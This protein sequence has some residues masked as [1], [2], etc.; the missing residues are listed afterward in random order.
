MTVKAQY[1]ILLQVGFKKP[2]RAIP[3]YAIISLK[4][5]TKGA[6]GALK[7]KNAHRF[8]PGTVALREIRRYQKSTELL[9]RKLPFQRL[10]REIAANHNVCRSTYIP[11]LLFAYPTSSE[12]VTIPRK[13]RPRSSGRFGGLS[14]LVIPRWP[15]SC[16]SCQTHHCPSQG[17]C[18]GNEVTQGEHQAFLK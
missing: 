5:R 8:R 7:E 17:R 18:F 4:K 12:R 15:G 1:D 14:H 10:V 16:N 2:V 6:K 3:K 13:G 11:L 9:I